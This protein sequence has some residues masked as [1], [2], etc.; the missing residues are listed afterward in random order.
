[1]AAIF[2]K[3]GSSIWW[4]MLEPSTEVFRKPKHHLSLLAW[5]PQSSECLWKPINFLWNRWKVHPREINSEPFLSYKSNENRQVELLCGEQKHRRMA[6]GQSEKPPPQFPGGAN[7]K[8]IGS[9]PAVCIYREFV[10]HGRWPGKQSFPLSSSGSLWEWVI[11]VNKNVLTICRAIHHVRFY[12][13]KGASGTRA[14]LRRFYTQQG[15]DG[16]LKGHQKSKSLSSARH[17]SCLWATKRLHEKLQFKVLFVKGLF[18]V[19]SR[20]VPSTIGISQAFHPLSWWEQLGNEAFPGAVGFASV[21][22]S[23]ETWP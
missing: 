11:Q 20:L 17:S 21:G 14:I 5:L 16:D 18:G 6:L 12:M 9:P 4:K 3:A 23:F 13:A 15:Q 19:P 7:V 22:A 1:M 8:L 10:L 2:S